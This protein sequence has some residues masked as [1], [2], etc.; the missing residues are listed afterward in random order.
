MVRIERAGDEAWA[1]VATRDDGKESVTDV[2]M[3]AGD[4]RV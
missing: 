2:A 3:C 1:G 4:T